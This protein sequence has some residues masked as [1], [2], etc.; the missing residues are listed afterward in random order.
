MTKLKQHEDNTDLYDIDE[1]KELSKSELRKSILLFAGP[2]VAELMLVSLISIVNLSMVGHLG[3]YAITAVGLTNQPVLIF[4]AVFQAFNVGATALISRFIGARD[5]V[6]AKIAVNQTL[7]VSAVLGLFFCILGFIFSE[8]IVSLMGA[9][10]DT[11]QYATLYMKYMSV[12]ILFQTI[13]TAITSILRGSGDSKSPMRYNIIAN[14]VNVVVG[15]TLIYGFWFIPSMGITGAAIATTLAKF[16]AFAFSVYV[17]YHSNYP[18][19]F[20]FKEKIKV[21]YAMLKRI[22][23]VGAGAAGEQ[24]VLRVGF[25]IFA[26][27]IAELG[28]VQFAAHQ[29]CDSVIAVSNNLAAGLSMAATSFMGR[30]LGAHRPD[31]GKAYVDE[32]K[33]IGIISAITIVAI[34]Y[35]G[36]GWIARIFTNDAETVKLASYVLKIGVLIIPGVNIQLILSG[37]LRGA[38]DTKWPLISVAL[39]LILIRIPLALVLIKVLNF[40]VAGAWISGITDQ[41]V[42]AV[43]VYFRFKNGKWKD[44]NV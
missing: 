5:H 25:F 39:G 31:V 36:S 13:S 2:C 17:L 8:G 26:K 9:K 12:G 22:A 18:I 16:S 27:L 20:S 29:I 28:T 24:L 32:L 11:V 23:G 34:F 42:R 30:S 4:I 40:G 41:T 19:S 38:G 43:V 6:N 44:R 10:E 33:K 3:S 21:D 15:Y 35:V 7:I 37:A 1:E 14:I